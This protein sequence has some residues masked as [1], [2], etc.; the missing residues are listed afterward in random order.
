MTDRMAASIAADSAVQAAIGRE[1]KLR[2][3]VEPV[4][5]EMEAAVLPRGQAEAFTARV[6]FLLSKHS[7]D[8]FTWIMNRDAYYRLRN[9]E[10]DV[11]L[12]PAPDAVSPRYALVA[13]FVPWP[14]N[15]AGL[16]ATRICAYMS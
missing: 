6:R 5:N 8:R 2:I 9:Q 13:R 10:L 11:P 12:G 15:R 7:P 16:A 4:H 1:G 14:M 3:V